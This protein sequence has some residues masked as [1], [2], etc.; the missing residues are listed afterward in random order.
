VTVP[1]IGILDDDSAVGE[2]ISSLV[3]SA[4]LR[5]VVFS[6][7]EALLSSDYLNDAEGLIVDVRMPRI[8]GLELQ[9][10]LAELAFS[11]PIIFATACVNEDMR[12]RALDRCAVAILEKPCGDAAFFGAMRP[13]LE[14]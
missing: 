4:G 7:R 9:E 10:R 13:A 2:S 11:I 5:A 12:K 6:S 3:R 14:Q 1:L 8:G